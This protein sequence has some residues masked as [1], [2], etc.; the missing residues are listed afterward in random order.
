MG[1]GGRYRD[2]LEKASNINEEDATSG[3]GMLRTEVDSLIHMLIPIYGVARRETRV[4]TGVRGF[5]N[6]NRL[7]AY[8]T[9][10]RTVTTNV[11]RDDATVTPNSPTYA[12]ITVQPLQSS[13]IVKITDKLIYDSVPGVVENATEA[14][15]IS[16]G[17][18]EDTELFTGDGTASSGNFTGLK[19]A[20]LGFN[21]SVATARTG[22]FTNFDPLLQ[23]QATVYPSVM[24][25]G[26]CKYYMHPF[27]FANFQTFKASTS[28]L[29]FYDIATSQWKVAGCPI[30]FSQ[31][32]DTPTVA[33]GSTYSIGAVPV[34]F[35]DMEKAVTMLIG[36]DMTLKML[37]ELYAATNEI[38]MRLTYDFAYGIILSAA[39]TRI[40]ITS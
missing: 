34:Y 1:D 35:G 7:D 8:P 14:L 19:T 16:A 22:S 13:G 17:L 30:E 18:A 5:M 39:M 24:K 9:F 4:I 15:S 11:N 20:T 21:N 36:R 38:G 2:L 29:Y 23:M 32:I 37:L 10:G 31:V 6:L 28:G 33:G 3:L 40:T 26:R 27:T 12:K 25:S